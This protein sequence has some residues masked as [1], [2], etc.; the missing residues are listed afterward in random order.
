MSEVW[1]SILLLLAIISMPIAIV[2]AASF[3][4]QGTVRVGCLP[5]ALI[6]LM[7][8]VTAYFFSLGFGIKLACDWYPSGNLCGLVGFLIT[9]PL[10]SS[11]ATILVAGLLSLAKT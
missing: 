3:Y 7:S 8:A 10:A 1:F 9:G 6:L 2:C 4:A 11:V 5:Y